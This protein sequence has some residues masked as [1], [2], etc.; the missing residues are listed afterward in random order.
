MG[1]DEVDWGDAN[2]VLFGEL[3]GLIELEQVRQDGLKLLDSDEARGALRQVQRQIE[4][5]KQQIIETNKGLVVS[6]A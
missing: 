3:N 4:A 1:N 6:Y 5:V 2:T